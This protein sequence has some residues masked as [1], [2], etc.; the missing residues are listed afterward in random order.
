MKKLSIFFLF[1]YVFSNTEFHELF[2]LQS[3]FV[4]YQEHLNTDGNLGFLK[5]I[6]LHYS[7]DQSHQD[8]DDDK[9]HL[10]FQD[11]HSIFT[12]VAPTKDLAS[13]II[14]ITPNAPQ[15]IDISILS[16]DF[17]SSSFV[18]QIWQPPKS[19]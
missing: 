10:P 16:E 11:H 2:K 19:C 1:F 6:H 14:K 9:E 15:T 12:V 17:Y 7:N 5:F 3:M 18:D 8:T 4:H 13:N